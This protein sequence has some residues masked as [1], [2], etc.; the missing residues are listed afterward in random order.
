MAVEHGGAARFESKRDVIKL[1]I[2]P[3]GRAFSVLMF[4]IQLKTVHA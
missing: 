1:T 4:N 2:H 3:G